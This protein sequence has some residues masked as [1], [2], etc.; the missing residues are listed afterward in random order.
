MAMSSEHRVPATRSR[1][2]INVSAET[3]AALRE[4]A[5]RDSTSITEVVRRAVG[6]YKLLEDKKA[7]GYR[8]QIAKGDRVGEL[9]LVT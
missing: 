3:A 2:T 4:I 8:L 6:V 7:E 5:D 1:L 9:L